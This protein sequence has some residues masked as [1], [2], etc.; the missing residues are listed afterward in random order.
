MGKRKLYKHGVCWELWCRGLQGAVHKFANGRKSEL[1]LSCTNG[2]QCDWCNGVI[3]AIMPTSVSR[4]Q[5]GHFG[6]YGTWRESGTYRVYDWITI[7]L[8]SKANISTC[9]INTFWNNKWKNEASQ[10][11]NSLQ[12]LQPI[13]CYLTRSALVERLNSLYWQYQKVRIESSGS[14]ALAP[15]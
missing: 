8:D 7:P 6:C 15:F 3:H 9:Y 13:G 10:A 14:L 11:S 1:W 4:F 2:W 5:K 12:H